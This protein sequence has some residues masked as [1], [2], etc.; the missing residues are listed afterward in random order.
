MTIPRAEDVMEALI[1][2]RILVRLLVLW[3]VVTGVGTFVAIATVPGAV[4]GAKA[5]AQGAMAP[6]W[7]DEFANTDIASLPDERAVFDQQETPTPQASQGTVQQ[8]ATPEVAPVLPTRIVIS[9]LGID[10]PVQNPTTTNVEALDSILAS[11]V[12]RYPQSGALNS[13][14][15]VL[16]F[17]HS[18]Y[19]PVVHNKLYKAFNGIQNLNYGDEIQVQS[20]DT[21]YV[22]QVFN[23]RKASAEDDEIALQTGKR[24][25]TL[26][27]CDSFGKQSDRF[28]V[29]AEFD[30]AF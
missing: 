21:T 6:L 17:G 30:R 13:T 9:K 16:I 20:G 11:A 19:L 27:T 7:F 26:L 4:F 15:N 2:P 22:Y 5:E 23:V 1:T 8:S 18:S 14:T 29:E 28:V 24:Q 10:L 12:V 3:F 25:I